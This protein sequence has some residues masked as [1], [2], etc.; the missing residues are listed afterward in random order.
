MIREKTFRETAQTTDLFPLLGIDYLEFY[1]GN[2]KQAAY[3][4]QSA[5]GFQPLAY[6]GL[7][8]GDRDTESYAVAQGNIRFVF[9]S[10]LHSQSEIGRHLDR[11]GDGIRVC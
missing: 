2:A 7:E 11:H 1:V 4:Y 10:P 6:R 9:T 8:T 5:F 3:Y